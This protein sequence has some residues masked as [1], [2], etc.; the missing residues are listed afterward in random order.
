MS[1]SGLLV[2]RSLVQEG[3]LLAHFASID[4]NFFLGSELITPIYVCACIY[5]HKLI[6]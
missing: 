2:T 3:S 1:F 5:A 6:F 4:N